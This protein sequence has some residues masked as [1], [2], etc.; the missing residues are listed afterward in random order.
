MELN[1]GPLKLCKQP[2]NNP[3]HQSHHSSAGSS[4]ASRCLSIFMAP[5][6]WCR[7][8]P[9][10][11]K[12]HPQ[13]W[14]I[15]RAPH[16][17]SA[18]CLPLFKIKTIHYFR[19]TRGRQTCRPPAARRTKL[20]PSACPPTERAR[21]PFPVGIYSHVLDV[22]RGQAERKRS[23]SRSSPTTTL[24]IYSFQKENLTAVGF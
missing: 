7:P 3:H 2:R 20:I 23:P 16:S 5:L 11:A 13:C 12:K 21:A 14:N 8:V 17:A 19:R 1:K 10:G 4:P 22:I 18:L 9:L 15:D 6:H 24:V